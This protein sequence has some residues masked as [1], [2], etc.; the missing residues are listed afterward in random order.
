MRNFV[1]AAADSHP[2]IAE[3]SEELRPLWFKR[4]KNSETG[5]RLFLAM[6]RILENPDDKNG[7]FADLLTFE[8]A[9][10]EDFT[11]WEEENPGEPFVALDPA[12][13]FYEGDTTFTLGSLD[14][15]TM[16]FTPE[17]MVEFILEKDGFTLDL[18]GEHSFWIEEENK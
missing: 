17:V 8:V 11:E 9:D 3:M 15:K 4:Y 16:M 7:P 1:T 5:E 14:E 13:L 6:E 10:V 12:Y 2:L 18:E